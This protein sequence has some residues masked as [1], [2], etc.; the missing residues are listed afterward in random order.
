MGQFPLGNFRIAVQADRQFS[1]CY[2]W[3]A[4]GMRR[5]NDLSDCAAISTS[6]HGDI[7]RDSREP[8]FHFVS[9]NSVAHRGIWSDASLSRMSSGGNLVCRPEP[10]VVVWRFLVHRS[11]EPAERAI[12][13]C[14]A[15]RNGAGTKAE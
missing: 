5:R 13:A 8:G 9:D 6:G 4:G 3:P 7:S 12:V 1:Y 15:G 14:T 11:D 2:L 10:V